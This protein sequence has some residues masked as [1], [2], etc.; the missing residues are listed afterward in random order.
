MSDILIILLIDHTQIKPIK[1]K[2][3]LISCHL[4]SF[5]TTVSLEESAKVSSDT[6]LKGI[7]K[8][9]DSIIIYS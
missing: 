5:F 3:H 1:G 2:Q 8:L 6:D 4:I 7:Q 9:Q